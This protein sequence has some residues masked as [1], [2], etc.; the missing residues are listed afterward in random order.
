MCFFPVFNIF[1]IKTPSADVMNAFCISPNVCSI[2]DLKFVSDSLPKGTLEIL[3]VSRL[4]RNAKPFP[5]EFFQV[6]LI[7]QLIK[8]G[9]LNDFVWKKIVIPSK[10]KTDWSMVRQK[11]KSRT[12]RY[13]T[14]VD[15]VRDAS[16]VKTKSTVLHP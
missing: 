8:L 9:V 10:L 16:D 1:L 15:F 13:Y 14:I 5:S 2:S 3:F 12:E 11:I 4:N 6:Y 7:F